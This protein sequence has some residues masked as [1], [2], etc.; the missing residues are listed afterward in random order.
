[1]VDKRNLVESELMSCCRAE[2]AVGHVRRWMM[3]LGGVVDG[4]DGFD[5]GT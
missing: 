3:V 4:L 5:G 1:M 2:W